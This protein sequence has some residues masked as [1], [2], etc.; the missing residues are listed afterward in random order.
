M[1]TLKFDRVTQSVPTTASEISRLRM[2]DLS[3]ASLTAPDFL[4]CQLLDLALVDIWATMLMALMFAQLLATFS[5]NSG[6][7]KLLVPGGTATR[8][9]A[10]LVTRPRDRQVLCA[11][12]NAGA[13]YRGGI[14]ENRV[15]KSTFSGSQSLRYRCSWYLIFSK[16]SGYPS[17]SGMRNHS[18]SVS[19]NFSH[20]G[21][22][23][24]LCVP[25]PSLETEFKSA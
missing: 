19:F 17:P 20:R 24:D 8:I 6:A 16:S 21:S 14:A 25:F 7:H 3:A 23:C 13:S 15:W 9:S 10:A 4:H 12:E 22:T 18:L 11:R 2:R 5:L 1:P